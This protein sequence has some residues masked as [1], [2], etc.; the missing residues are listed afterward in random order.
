MSKA[1]DYYEVLGVEI[2]ATKEEIVKAYRK[3]ALKLHPDKQENKEEAE[4]QF[5][6]LAG[7]YGVLKDDTQRT[8][9][10]QKRHLILAGINQEEENVINLY[11]YFNTNCFDNYDDSETGFYTVFNELFK[12]IENEEGGG[13]QMCGFGKSNSTI[14]E[15]KAFYEN[16]KYFCSKLEFYDK[17]PNN[18]ADAPNQQV[19]RG[20]KKENEKVRDKLRNERT[21]NVRQLVNYVQRLDPRWDQVKA[22]MRRQKEL[23][24]EK[25]AKQE[26][27]RQQREHERRQKELESFKDF[28]LPQEEEDEIEK[29]SKY[30]EGKA[31]DTDDEKEVEEFCCVVCDKKFKSEGQLK[32][33]ENSKKHKQMLKLLRKE[34][35]KIN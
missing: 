17:L 3:L 2:T 8:W 13:K 7:A 15:V 29:L 19:R 28:E 20:W 24:E 21:Q 10:D 25:E 6:E 5:Q 1:R 26:A 23:R 22:E 30:Y 27:A 9:Y 34:M 4:K 18:I 33:H 35:E 12:N 11:E 16:W 32:T 31:V 14:N